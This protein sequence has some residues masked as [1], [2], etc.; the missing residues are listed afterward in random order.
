MLGYI[1]AALTEWIAIGA[2]GELPL[3]VWRWPFLVEVRTTTWPAVCP[4]KLLLM[5]FCTVALVSI[6]DRQHFFSR[7]VWR[8]S[9]FLK[10]IS[11]STWASHLTP[12]RKRAEYGE[13]VSI[14][15]NTGG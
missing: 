5:M 12:A 1:I 3:E 11:H 14:R 9:L 6:V 15:L 13:N 7:S 8:S 4:L 10:S 2:G